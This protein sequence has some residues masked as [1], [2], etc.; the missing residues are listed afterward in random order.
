MIYPEFIIQHNW[1]FYP[2]YLLLPIALQEN[3]ISYFT[4]TATVLPTL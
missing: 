4:T 1:R 2:K 3:L